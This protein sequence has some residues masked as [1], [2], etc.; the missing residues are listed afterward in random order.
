MKYV[1]Q[2][3]RWFWYNYIS[4]AGGYRLVGGGHMYLNLFLLIYK[5]GDTAPLHTDAFR[6]KRHI[7]VNLRLWGEDTFQMEGEP[8]FKLGPLVIF[9]AGKEHWTTPSKRWRVLLSFGMVI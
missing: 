6:G 4:P 2:R 8:I 1:N 9:D 7:R 3:P 5:P